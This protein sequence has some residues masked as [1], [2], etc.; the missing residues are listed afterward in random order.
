MRI[1]ATIIDGKLHYTIE[2]L[3]DTNTIEVITPKGGK[4][5]GTS[6]AFGDLDNQPPTSM[7]VDREQAS[8]FACTLPRTKTIKRDINLKCD[9]VRFLIYSTDSRDEHVRD[10]TE[11]PLWKC[12]KWQMF[13]NDPDFGNNALIWNFVT[14]QMIPIT[15]IRCFLRN[16]PPDRHNFKPLL[17]IEHDLTTAIMMVDGDPS[18]DGKLETSPCVPSAP[19]DVPPPPYETPPQEQPKNTTLEDKLGLTAKELECLASLKEAEGEAEQLKQMEALSKARH[20]QYIQS[21]PPITK[22]E[23]RLL[24]T[25]C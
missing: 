20:I 3:D 4:F 24:K 8:C 1:R 9:F 5:H 18:L 17:D 21:L 23:M 11:F 22:E 14:G 19:A 7:E 12:V 2:S 15:P 10:F 13:T 6:G 16:K 25:F